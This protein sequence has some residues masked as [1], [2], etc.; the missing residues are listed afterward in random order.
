[1][2]LLGTIS[3]FAALSIKWCGISASH[4]KGWKL[5][6]LFWISYLDSAQ[7]PYRT[8]SQN[9]GCCET[10]W[11]L[12]LPWPWSPSPSGFDG[13][14]IRNSDVLSLPKLLAVERRLAKL[15]I[16]WIWADLQLLNSPGPEAKEWMRLIVPQF[17]AGGS[18]VGV[19]QSRPSQ[20]SLPA[21]VKSFQFVTLHKL[22]IFFLFT[23]NVCSQSPDKAKLHFR[24]SLDLF[25][26]TTVEWC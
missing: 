6:C 4:W 24:S 17:I 2:F 21:F 19:R 11:V 14:G 18:A 13:H 10:L 26:Q 9:Y 20:A 7:L 22:R 3:L 15:G 16:K 23:S 5:I 1:M 12:L 25:C 8:I